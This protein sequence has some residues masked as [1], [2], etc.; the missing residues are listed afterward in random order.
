MNSPL[1]VLTGLRAQLIVSKARREGRDEI[2][3]LHRE[4]LLLT[5]GLEK[6]LKLEALKAFR[7]SFEGWAPREYLRKVTKPPN[8]TPDDMHT[9]IRMYLNEYIKAVEEGL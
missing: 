1:N 6:K 3:A 4:G 5:P 9:A 2:E 7:Q 8:W